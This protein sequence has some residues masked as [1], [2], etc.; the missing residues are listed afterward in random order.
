MIISFHVQMRWTRKHKRGILGNRLSSEIGFIIYR[1]HKN[2]VQQHIFQKGRSSVCL[3]T[4]S[5]SLFFLQ[6]SLL[7]LGSSQ[8]HF[9]AVSQRCQCQTKETYFEWKFLMLVSRNQL[10]RFNYHCWNIQFCDSKN[11]IKSL[12]HAHLCAYILGALKAWQSKTE[13]F[14]SLF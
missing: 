9:S 14:P 4:T 2:R 13:L 3:F 10:N 5:P 1:V 6:M 12:V 7:L 11:S 8:K